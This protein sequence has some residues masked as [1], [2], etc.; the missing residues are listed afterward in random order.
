MNKSKYLIK[1]A[2]EA[3]NK[4]DY[5]T[6]ID[7]Y[8]KAIIEYPELSEIIMANIYY[9]R[10]KCFKNNSNFKYIFSII[11]PIYNREKFLEKS[12][13]TSKKNH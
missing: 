4:D 6:A 13:N 11:M 9:L 8:E 2:Q 12:I 10:K 5:N 7:F 3:Y 1:Q